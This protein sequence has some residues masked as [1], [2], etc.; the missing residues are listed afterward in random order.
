[1]VK[2]KRYDEVKFHEFT[3]L[4]KETL[5]PELTQRFGD[6]DLL[7]F[8]VANSGNVKNALKQLTGALQ[9]HS[10]TINEPFICQKCCDRPSSH[11]HIPIGIET[12][13]GSCIFYGSP[14][15]SG[16]PE[17]DVLATAPIETL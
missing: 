16:D 2:D 3:K 17:V 5:G 12:T 10:K 1:M 13:E 8:I 7:R 6:I 11:S 4:A 9:W 14:A 15:R